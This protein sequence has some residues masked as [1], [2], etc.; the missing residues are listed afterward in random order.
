MEALSNAMQSSSSMSTMLNSPASTIG[1]ILILAIGLFIMYKV[2]EKAGIEGW[3][4]LIPFY[5][6]YLL[7]EL[8]WG[9]GLYALL[10]LIPIV[11]IIVSFMTAI[12]LAKAFGKGTGFGIGLFFIPLVFKGIIAFGDAKYEGVP[13]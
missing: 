5:N 4:A 7:Y 1:Y 9:K 13:A 12:K 10:L 3:K 6:V 2:F 8:T 11:N